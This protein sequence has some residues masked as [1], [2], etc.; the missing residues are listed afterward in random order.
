MPRTTFSYTDES[1]NSIKQNWLSLSIFRWGRVLTRRCLD[2]G[3]LKLCL[4]TPSKN[5]VSCGKW[6]HPFSGLG[7]KPKNQLR[8]LKSVRVP[9]SGN[10]VSTKNV[11]SRTGGLSMRTATTDPFSHNRILREKTSFAICY[12][13][14]AQQWQFSNRFIYVVILT[15]RLLNP[16]F[17]KS[18]CLSGS[19]KNQP[20]SGIHGQSFLTFSLWNTKS[21]MERHWWHE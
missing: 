19:T 16:V 11:T 21:W 15:N 13:R 4:V 14:W 2:N 12:T 1:A 7:E 17:R 6:N 18:L 9:V 20:W 5:S 3:I 8:R 10:F